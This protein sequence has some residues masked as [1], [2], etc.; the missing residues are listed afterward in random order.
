[1]S[2]ATVESV[3]RALGYHKIQSAIGTILLFLFFVVLVAFMFMRVHAE[4]EISN[5]FLEIDQYQAALREAGKLRKSLTDVNA[6][7]NFIR[8]KAENGAPFTPGASLRTARPPFSEEAVGS[9]KGPDFDD[10]TDDNDVFPSVSHPERRS[11]HENYTVFYGRCVFSQSGDVIKVDVRKRTPVFFPE[12]LAKFALSVAAMRN[13][14]DDA[15]VSRDQLLNLFCGLRGL[16]ELLEETE[17]ISE[18]D[19]KMVGEIV[20]LQET[21]KP[22]AGRGE[23]SLENS[24]RCKNYRLVLS[25]IAEISTRSWVPGAFSIDE[26]REGDATCSVTGMARK[27]VE[28]LSNKVAEVK[29]EALGDRLASKTKPLTDTEERKVRASKFV[30]ADRLQKLLDSAASGVSPA[31]EH[32]IAELKDYLSRS[33]KKLKESLTARPI[34]EAGSRAREMFGWHQLLLNSLL[35][36]S[37]LAATVASAFVSRAHSFEVVEIER[38]Q[39]GIVEGLATQNPFGKA[40]RGDSSIVA[41]V[42]DGI[43]SFSLRPKS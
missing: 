39:R 3:R 24:E 31:E 12:A 4:R 11:L 23:K 25:R 26:H 40:A 10:D 30:L 38:F 42:V 13:L 17:V 18:D 41:A 7:L 21:L 34:T 22:D 20:R 5:Q 27:Y 14:E 32:R 29:G 16:D 36:G 28:F 1:M 37:T 9:P 8:G 33:E 15:E 6:E 35:V 43:K 19:V 2:D